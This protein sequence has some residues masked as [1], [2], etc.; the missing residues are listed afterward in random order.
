MISEVNY[1]IKC[2]VRIAGQRPFKC[3]ECPKAFKHRHHL[4]SQTNYK[5]RDVYWLTYFHRLNTSVCT[6]VKSPSNAASVWS[7]SPI[8]ARTVSTW[9][10]DTA[11]ANLI[12]TSWW[13]NAGRSITISWGTRTFCRHFKRNE[14]RQWSECDRVAVWIKWN[15]IN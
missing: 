5:L 2:L 8:P 13:C 4:V 10:T 14:E 3:T 7:A 12:E 6:Q 9:T 11:T 1:L 15:S